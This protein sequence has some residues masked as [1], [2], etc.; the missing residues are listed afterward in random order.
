MK[1][2]IVICYLLF[3]YQSNGQM[4]IPREI[5]SDSTSNS[6]NLIPS[7]S[8]TYMRYEPGNLWT[9]TSKGL[10]RTTDFGNSWQ[11]FRENS[12]FPH[13]GIFSLATR[14]NTI[15][16]STGFD[17]EI[18]GGSVQTGGGYT[19]S[20]DNG[21]S[22]DYVGQTQDDPNAKYIQYGV[23]DSVWILPITV[24]Q[25]NVTF[26]ISLTPAGVVYIASWSS[27][28]R[29]SYDNGATWERILLPLDNKTSISPD[30]TL[31]TYAPTDTLHQQR[32]FPRY[33]PRQN[34]NMLAFSV[35]AVDDDIIW[36]GT[37]GGVNKSTDGGS[38]WVRFTHQNQT[39]PILGNWVIAID[40]ENVNGNSR[41]WTTNWRAS[42]NEEEYGVSYT[43]DAG[44]NW[45]NL[46]RG[47][48]AYDFAF[49]GSIVYIATD[50]GIY[51]TEDL[52][53]TFQQFSN[54]I[55]V[56]PRTYIRSPKVYS[57]VV[58]DDT[59]FVGT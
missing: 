30:D 3:V 39:K 45:T 50:N 11:S 42:D 2:L 19:F 58:V 17:T 43:D 48:K 37:A 53:V 44:L 24:P 8:V 25:Q 15:W 9:G 38:S 41:I 54:F 56:E 47:V 28:L 32:I 13:D 33:D 4:N 12:Q 26:D 21:A 36:C 57:V 1:K 29:R 22:W 51:R 31:W 7:N 5:R 10:A 59:V 55:D 40:E 27:S 16:T 20:L 23:N 46:L 6:S 18:E 49:K 34:N 52:G 14:G 35:Y